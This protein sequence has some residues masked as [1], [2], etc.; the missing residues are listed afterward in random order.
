MSPFGWAAKP[1][2]AMFEADRSLYTALFTMSRQRMHLV[3]LA[4]AHWPGEIDQVFARL[5]I[6]G[7]P[8][9]VLDAVLGRRPAGLRRAL[10]H[11]PVG[12]VPQATYRQ[13][14]ELL[15]EPAVAKFLP[16]RCAAGEIP[17][18]VVQHPGAAAPDRSRRDR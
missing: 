10:G 13:L 5:L 14:V 18:L 16:L 8:A 17:W 15:E 4:L 9:A 6:R 2:G 11:L 1:L 7:A 3:A 12:V